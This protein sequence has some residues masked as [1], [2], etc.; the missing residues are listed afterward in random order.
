M[1]ERLRVARG[2]DGREV[3]VG[4]VVEIRVPRI[5]APVDAEGKQELVILPRLIVDARAD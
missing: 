3:A 2:E 1:A 4:V 5:A